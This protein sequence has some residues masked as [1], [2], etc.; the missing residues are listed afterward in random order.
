MVNKC[1]TRN[2]TRDQNGHLRSQNNRMMK[3][4]E[5][6]CASSKWW[7]RCRS[8]TSCRDRIWLRNGSSLGWKNTSLND[9]ASST[10][11]YSKHWRIAITKTFQM[12][13]RCSRKDTCIRMQSSL[14]FQGQSLWRSQTFNTWSRTFFHCWTSIVSTQSTS[15][16]NKQ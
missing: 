13:S 3:I 8:W 7:K 12:L 14:L 15:S 2:R 4:V 10:G 16:P 6:R 11:R 5:A 1:L 9:W